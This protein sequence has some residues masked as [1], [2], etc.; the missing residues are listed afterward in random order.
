MRLGRRLPALVAL[1]ALGACGTNAEVHTSRADPIDGATVPTDSPDDTTGPT[2][3]TPSTD[4]PDTTDAPNNDTLDWRACDDPKAEDPTLEC[5]TLKVPLD[6][7]NPTGDSIDLALIKYPASGDRTGAVLLNPGGPGGS[8][9]DPIAFS[10]PAIAQSLGIGSLDLIGFDPRGV[11]RSSGLRC[12]TDQFM[13]E[14]LYVDETPDTP[15]EQALKDELDIGF[16]DAC[17]QK[18]GD[19]LRFYSTENTARDMD[20]IREALG[21]DQISY[22]GISYGTYLGATY[23][24]MFPDQVRAMVLDSVV[25]PNGDTVQQAFETQLVGFEG[26]FNNWVTWCQ[27]NEACEF[28]TADVG[29]R[30]DALRQELD[31]TPITGDDGRVGN[32]TTMVRATQAALY[33][34]NQ[35]PVLGEALAKAEAGDPAG[36]FA[37][38]D[39]YN[40]RN[41]DGTFNTL[42]Q[43]FPVISCAS[44]IGAPLPPDPEGLLATLQAAAPRMAKA[45]TTRDLTL[46]SERCTEMVGAVQPVQISYDGDGPIVL[47]GGTN[48]PATPIRWAQKMVD[49]LGPNAEL[50]TYTGEGHGQLLVSK[51]VT[52]IEGTLLADLTLPD[53]DTVCDPDPIVEKP[54]WWDTLPVPD[55]ISDVVSLPALNAATGSSPTQFFSEMRTT[56]LSADEAV[57]AYTDALA[58]ADFQEFDAPSL[59]AID[60]VKQGAYSDFAN[61]TL[62]VL[63]L[64]PD[65]FEDEALQSAKAEVPPDTTV[66]WLI[67]I[68]D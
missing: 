21:D 42:F 54:D 63:A 62:V 15:E 13:D 65:A 52:D 68:G 48:D 40:G 64:G 29:A 59:L 53:P 27:T 5:A 67:A 31:D 34:E 10:G 39:S 7:D 9:F 25:E 61:K 58:D 24:T 28:K 12:E 56:S 47:V 30:W 66:V 6:Y 18:Y 23:A 50:V 43:S 38:A 8:G 44:G 55:G 17:T 35:W 41:D 32:N 51:C 26:A 2:D 60:A 11:D 14:H 1:M 4:A 37:I 46:D 20:A 19:T 22:L 57:A 36:I 16:A 49:E 33:S 3:S 45:L